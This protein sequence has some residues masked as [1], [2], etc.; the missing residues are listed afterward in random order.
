MCEGVVGGKNH[1]KESCR[2]QAYFASE[3]SLLFWFDQ[4]VQKKGRSSYLW[5]KIPIV[6][7][8]IPKYMEFEENTNWIISVE[9]AKR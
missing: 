9:W 4:M 1:T 5:S 2:A 3:M 7:I 8:P 6:P